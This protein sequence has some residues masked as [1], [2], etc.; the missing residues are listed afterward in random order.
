[1]ITGDFKRIAT[2]CDVLINIFKRLTFEDQLRLAI[3]NGIFENIFKSYI[4]KDSYEILSMAKYDDEYWVA[5]GKSLRMLK[6][7]TNGYEAFIT[8]YADEVKELI[9]NEMSLP[10]MNRFKN[11]KILR[12]LYNK[13]MDMENLKN[14]IMCLTGLKDLYLDEKPCRSYDKLIKPRAYMNF[15]FLLNLKKLKIISIKSFSNYPP[16]KYKDLIQIIQNNN[17]EYLKLDCCIETEIEIRKYS[18]LW[19]PHTLK[20]LRELDM[21]ISLLPEKWDILN[22]EI[23]SQTLE[24]LKTLYLTIIDPVSQEILENLADTC[25]HLELLTLRQTIFQYIDSLRLPAHLKELS[26]FSCKN[27]KHKHLKEILMREN[28]EK[29][30]SKYTLYQ[31][32]FEEFTISPSIQTLAL[33]SMDTCRLSSSFKGNRT[34]LKNLSWYH[35]N[36]SICSG[37]I[38]SSNLMYCYNLEIL[39]INESL[40]DVKQLLGLKYLRQLTI[41]FVDAPYMWSYIMAILKHSSLQELHMEKCPSTYNADLI[42]IHTSSLQ[43]ISTTVRHITLHIGIIQLA[44][45][46][47]IDLFARHRNLKIT[48]LHFTPYDN[49][50]LHRIIN[51]RNFPHSIKEILIYGF[52][53]DCNEMRR[54]CSSN[55]FLLEDLRKTFQ[56][57]DDSIVISRIL[58]KL[59]KHNN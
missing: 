15:E 38:F 39:Q 46:F 3:V 7:K 22:F 58:N 47:W 31:G 44:F 17:L 8:C 2:N 57:A 25:K 33:D 32:V 49:E 19:K 13:D 36:P 30:I 10:D 37:L 42:E 21:K 29:F 5:S 4:W 55:I 23:F 45:D 9:V 59:N 27:L 1:M 48:I 35:T 41:P 43:E 14:A 11:L 53:I 12:Y 34:R 51:H 56:N 54:H 24:N 40:M 16:V 50:L 20:P 52:A 28:L 18:E 6:L 26:L